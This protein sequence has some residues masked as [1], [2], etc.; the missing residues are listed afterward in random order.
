[1]IMKKDIKK[2]IA[3]AI[4]TGAIISGGFVASEKA[5]CDYIIE[6][7]GEK[8]CFTQE[9]KEIIEKGLKQNNGFGGVRFNQK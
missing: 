8:I 4:T 7:Q 5:N 9:E 3:T 1:M 6:Y 2:I